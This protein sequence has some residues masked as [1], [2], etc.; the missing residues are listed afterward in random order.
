MSLGD[1]ITG[2][3][4]Y[5]PDGALESLEWTATG[6]GAVRSHSDL[7][8][9]IAGMLTSEDVAILN[10]LSKPAG[11]TGGPA[12]CDYDLAGRLS[13]WSTRALVQDQAMDS[14]NHFPFMP[15]TGSLV[16]SPSPDP[17]M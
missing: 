2:A 13:Q 12:S 11:D 5:H 14:F 8:Y 4:G 16:P 6:L 3:F 1:D 17:S 15:G 10:P 7:T 9:N